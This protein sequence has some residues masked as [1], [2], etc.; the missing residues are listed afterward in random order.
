MMFLTLFLYDT[1]LESASIKA[2]I[3]Y[4]KAAPKWARVIHNVM[5]Q[6]VWNRYFKG[7]GFKLDG[8]LQ[9]DESQYGHVRKSFRGYKRM[10]SKIWVFRLTCSDTNRTLLFPVER[11]FVCR[12]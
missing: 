2:G 10:G 1:S 7:A 5:V 9:A 11:R 12:L 3:N 6:F 8:V 4:S